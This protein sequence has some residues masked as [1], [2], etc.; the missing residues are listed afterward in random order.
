MTPLEE[1]ILFETSEMDSRDAMKY[2]LRKKIVATGL[3]VQ[4]LQ[5]EV[6]GSSPGFCGCLPCDLVHN[7]EIL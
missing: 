1:G 6:G 3:R 4:T 7:I 2:L 5:L